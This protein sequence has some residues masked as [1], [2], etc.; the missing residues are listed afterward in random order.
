MPAT[1]CKCDDEVQAIV[2][3]MLKANHLKRI[4]LSDEDLTVGCIFYIPGE[5]DPGLRLHGYRC[6]A[7]IKA[8]SAK[9][10]AQGLPDAEITI[11]HETWHNMEPAERDALIDHELEHLDVKR[12]KGAI[13][14]DGSGR[15]VIKLRLHDWELGGFRVIAERH[16]KNAPEVRMA[17]AFATD[18]GQ[19]LFPFAVVSKRQKAEEFLTKGN[20]TPARHLAGGKDLTD[21][22]AD[23][24]DGAGVKYERNVLPNA[25]EIARDPK[26]AAAVKEII[27]KNKGD[28]ITFE[29]GGRSVTIDHSNRDRIKAKCDAV[30]SAGRR[31]ASKG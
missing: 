21:K 7:I 20:S 30:I 16:G 18:Y 6:G 4:G 12:T 2:D 19:L 15:P 14:R 26:I 23:A 5:K 11:D 31:A 9:H 22:V 10:R 27:P 8:N 28:S 29:S 13:K 17:Q 1:Y 3:R 25:A 24:L